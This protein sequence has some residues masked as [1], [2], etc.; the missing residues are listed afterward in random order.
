M[1]VPCMIENMIYNQLEVKRSVEENNVEVRLCVFDSTFQRALMNG[2]E[3]MDSSTVHANYFECI[4][5][6]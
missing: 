2:N 6:M 5:Q 3:N 1:P 4:Q